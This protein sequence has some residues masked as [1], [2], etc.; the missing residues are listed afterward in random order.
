MSVDRI[1]ILRERTRKKPAKITFHYDNGSLKIEGP[2]RT[3]FPLFNMCVGDD[4]TARI[5]RG[6]SICRIVQSIGCVMSLLFTL[7]E[8]K[9]EVHPHSLIIEDAQTDTHASGCTD[10]Q[11]H[12][13][14]HTRTLGRTHTYAHSRA[15][16]NA[17]L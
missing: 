13:D 15:H 2:Y 3:W 1:T 5:T 16:P 6:F 4:E 12:S 10:T 8:Q 17:T 11:V 7:R 14:G 9:K